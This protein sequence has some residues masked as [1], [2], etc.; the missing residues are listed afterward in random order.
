MKTW[1]CI[2]VTYVYNNEYTL[3]STCKA[4][5]EY[6]PGRGDLRYGTVRR[7]GG[8][9]GRTA[10]WRIGLDYCALDRLIVWRRGCD[11]EVDGHSTTGT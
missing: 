8:L 5:Y 4:G 2:F 7:R 3:S 10:I 1:V 9:E 6:E 11:L